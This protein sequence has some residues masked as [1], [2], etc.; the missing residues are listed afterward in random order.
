MS[1]KHRGGCAVWMWRVMISALGLNVFIV[2]FKY[3]L[4]HG[5]LFLVAL[6]LGLLRAVFSASLF[7]ESWPLLTPRGWL[8]H[9]DV[10]PPGHSAVIPWP[11]FPAATWMF[12]I[13]LDLPG[14]KTKSEA[15]QKHSLSSCLCYRRLCWD[16]FMY[17]LSSTI[18]KGCWML[19]SPFER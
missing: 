9:L 12:L 17:Y 16:R 7:R 10:C 1:V 13:T 14:L 15:V 6:H 11:A 8:P 4:F 18:T 2:L 3:A 5:L 19:L